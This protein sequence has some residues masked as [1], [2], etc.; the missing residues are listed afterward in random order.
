M[1]SLNK[2]NREKKGGAILR[3]VKKRGQREAK[4]KNK[5]R[6]GCQSE[7]DSFSSI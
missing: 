1:K 7:N 4:Q 5:E 2:R 6:E 3:K